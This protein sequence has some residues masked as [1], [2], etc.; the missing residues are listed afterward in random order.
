MRGLLDTHVLLWWLVDD[1]RLSERARTLVADPG[2]DLFFSAASSWE[3]SIKAALGRLELPGPPRTLIPKILRQQSIEPVQITH[4]HALAVGELPPHH[5][6]PFDRMLIA[7]GKLE[8][9][10]IV[11]SDPVFARYGAKTVW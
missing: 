4:A 7:Q 6:D 3:I 8:K 1:A 11:T 5:R 10:P 9:L 2:T